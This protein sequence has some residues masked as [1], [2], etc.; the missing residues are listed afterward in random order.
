MPAPLGPRSKCKRPGRTREVRIRLPSRRAERHREGSC[1][2]WVSRSETPSLFLRGLFCWRPGS[3]VESGLDVEVTSLPALASLR[4]PEWGASA[5]SP[6]VLLSSGLAWKSCHGIVQHQVVLA[7]QS[8][9][10]LPKWIA[11]RWVP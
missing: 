4:V 9:A 10:G 5:G 11:L 6:S 3:Q 8:N 7:A 1:R 2:G